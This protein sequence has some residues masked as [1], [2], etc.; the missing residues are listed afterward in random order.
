MR[1]QLAQRPG[2][3][4]VSQATVARGRAARLRVHAQAATHHSSSSS[5][6]PLDVVV[7]GAGIGGLV[8]ASALL[9]AGARVRVYE[10]RT[11]EQALDGP[12]G[13]LVQANGEKVMR[14]LDSPWPPAAAAGTTP[15]PSPGSPAPS[16]AGSSS[17]SATAAA[18]MSDAIYEVGGPVLSGGFRSDR[19]DYLYY[20]AVD[21]TGLTDLRSNGLGISRTSLQ[22]ILYTALP[23]GT[24]TFGRQLRAFAAPP[25]GQPGAVKVEFEDGSVETCDVL[26]A[27]DGVRS[28]VRAQVLR[29]AAGGE[30]APEKLRY[31]GTVCWRGRIPRSRVGKG[32]EW[33]SQQVGGDTWAEY[34]GSGVRF[35]F[36]NVGREVV[37][38][39][40][41]PGGLR[42]E[43]EEQIAWYAFDNRPEDWAP[44]PGADEVARLAALFKDFATPVPQVIAA[45]DPASVSYG[46]IYD[47]LPRAAPWASGR[48]TLMG[49]AAHAMMPTLGQGGCMA[50]ED[51]L[52]LANEL[53]AAAAAGAGGAE[54]GGAQTDAAAAAALEAGLRRYEASRAPRT[55]RVADQSYQVAELAMADKPLSVWLRNTIYR[56]TPKW[57]GDK[58]FEYLYLDYVPAWK[59]GVRQ[60]RTFGAA[61]GHGPA[62][63]AAAQKVGA[64]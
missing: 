14:L 4:R 37:R 33:L 46:R 61:E 53:M 23:A 42:L 48:V 39:A 51:G 55:S 32:S 30:A 38:D 22:N 21:S 20:A 13:I 9:E 41:A 25:P 6:R 19:G 24:V 26:I 59:E 12:G 5:K 45:L 57:A 7:V 54:G 2:S 62:A 64:A 10:S 15:S 11:L 40:S 47:Q 50:I 34:W 58:Q 3:A 17:S 52:E 60:G 8:T 35:G 49:D 63:P 56:L 28:K 16:K 27:S 44:E 31:S 43:G 36:F 1:T 18:T 29:E